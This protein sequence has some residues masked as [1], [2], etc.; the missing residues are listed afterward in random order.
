MKKTIVLM[1]LAA[2]SSWAQTTPSAAT[3]LVPYAGPDTPQGTGPYPAIMV[4]EKSLPTHTVYRPK[5]LASLK[6][7]KLPVIAW[8]NGACVNLGNR[9][10]YF[11][12]EIASN[13]FMAISIGPIGPNDAELAPQPTAAG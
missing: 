3:R 10:R 1:F 12:T 13:G 4:Q 5:D 7:Q 9:F 8:G 2:V 11:L 6:G